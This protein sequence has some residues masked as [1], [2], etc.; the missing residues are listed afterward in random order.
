[1]GLCGRFNHQPFLV[2]ENLVGRLLNRWR[3][4]FFGILEEK[5]VLN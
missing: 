2:V 5:P 1:L 4:F 3:W